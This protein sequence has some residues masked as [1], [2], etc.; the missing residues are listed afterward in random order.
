M[1]IKS[2]R[3]LVEQG[4]HLHHSATRRGYTS[5]ELRGKVATPYKGRFGN[6]YIVPMGRY[7][8]DGYKFST[9]YEVISYYVK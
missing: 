8:K 4:Y 3:D 1:K 2:T 6:G 7:T 5:V 9:N